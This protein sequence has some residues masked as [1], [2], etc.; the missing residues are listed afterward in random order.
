[1]SAIPPF[2]EEVIEKIGAVLGH[3]NSGFTGPEIAN[4]LRQARIPDPGEMTKRHRVNQALR[5]C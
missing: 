2:D 3:T 1:M 5:T 4:L